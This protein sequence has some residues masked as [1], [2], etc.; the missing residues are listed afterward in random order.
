MTT[1]VTG[2]GGFIAG[3]LIAA[4]L[5][6]GEQVRAVDKRPFGQ[7][8][9]VHG[10]AENWCHTDLSWAPACRTAV[11]GCGQVYHLAADTGGMG[12]IAANRAACMMNAVADAHMVRAAADA[13]ARF[14]FA[15]SSC[16]YP[17]SRQAG[18]VPAVLAEDWAWPADPE[19]GYGLS[20]LHTEQ[21]CLFAAAEWGL[22]PR[23]G[24]H[25]SIFGPWGWYDGGREKVPTAV[26]RKIAVAKLRG[27]HHIELWGD[28]SQARDF[29]YVSDAVAAITGIMAS[30]YDEPLN[31]GTGTATTVAGLVAM[32]GEIAGWPV[33]IRRAAEPVPGV[34]G[35]QGRST[36]TALVAE[37]ADWKAQVSV[38]E[39]MELTY[40][41]VYDQVKAMSP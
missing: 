23:I 29:V 9:Q 6:R 1:L 20:K 12:Y 28:G 32:T 13:G 41:W 5:Q 25:Q 19:P 33:E 37:H 27:E 3:H 4:L 30:D 26:C 14:Y 31:L 2:G 40:P 11:Y 17:V 24:R 10:G 16:V 7:W 22:T 35:V 36:D 34:V 39:G 8:K 21:L 38:R 18:P 15:S